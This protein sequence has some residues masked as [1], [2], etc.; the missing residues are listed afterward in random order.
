M[1]NQTQSP[2]IHLAFFGDK[3]YLFED[4]SSNSQVAVFRLLKKLKS[5]LGELPAR[6]HTAFR[7]NGYTSVTRI[8]ENSYYDAL[9]I[10]WDAHESI[11][12]NNINILEVQDIYGSDAAGGPVKV[13]TPQMGTRIFSNIDEALEQLHRENNAGAKWLSALDIDKCLS[14][15]FPKIQAEFL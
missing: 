12:S 5:N 13:T 8:T 15:N 6:L 7:T 4:D 14:I 9:T 10:L 3:S 1:K 2:N 11:K